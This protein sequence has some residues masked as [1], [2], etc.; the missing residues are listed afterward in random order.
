MSKR[1]TI[2]IVLLL[3]A[4]LCLKAQAS[5]SAAREQEEYAVYSAVIPPTYQHD[6]SGILVIANPTWRYPNE[7]SR[8][9]LRFIYPGSVVFQETLDDFIERNKTNRWLERKFQLDFAYTLA[10]FAEIKRLTGQNPNSDWKDF[11][12]RYPSS[13]GFVHYSRVG[14]NQRMDQALVYGGW[15]CPYLCGYWEFILLEKNRRTWK[16][17]NLANRVVS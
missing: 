15:A 13:H 14:F 16:V 12:K 7:I 4:P 9:D 10:D 8:N 17:I 5:E 2:A 11:L 6:E 1:F 3:A